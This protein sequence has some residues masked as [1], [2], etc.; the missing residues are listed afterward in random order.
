MQVRVLLSHSSGCFDASEY[1]ALSLD[2]MLAQSY[3]SEYCALSL[4]LTLAQSSVYC[5]LMTVCV[6]SRA[7]RDVLIA[8]LC[9]V[10]QFGMFALVVR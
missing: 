3:A 8:V 9:G 5:A 1:C 6:V 10:A 2:L 7:V 4:D